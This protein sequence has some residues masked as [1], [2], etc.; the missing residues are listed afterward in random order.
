MG[1]ADIIP[2]VAS[3]AGAG[4]SAGGQAGANQMNLDIAREQSMFQERMANSAQNFSERMAN[5][6]VQ[7]RVADLRAA[8]L[9]PALAYDSS[10]A[11]PTGVTAGGS[12]ARMENVMRDA[13]TIAANALS[14]KQMSQAIDNARRT[15]DAEVKLKTNQ[16][17]AAKSQADLGHFQTQFGFHMQPY[18][19]RNAQIENILGGLSLPG[20]RGA[21]NLE[22]TLQKLGGSG[23]AK[24]F[25]EFMRGITGMTRQGTTINKTIQLRGNP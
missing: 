15:T 2:A 10:A 9:N 1:W 18:H 14:I 12:Q 6:Q 13:P 7:R 5:T 17:A 4:I 24:L 21:A 22:E 25:L 16:A 19:I 8:G 23:S 11:A 3:I 20:A